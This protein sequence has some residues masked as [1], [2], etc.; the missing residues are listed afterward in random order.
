MNQDAGHGKKSYSDVSL[1]D[2]PQAFSTHK[3]AFDAVFFSGSN[4]K[5]EY[6]VVATERKPNSRINAICYIRVG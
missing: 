5:G 1:M 2:K 4:D 6:F 3:N